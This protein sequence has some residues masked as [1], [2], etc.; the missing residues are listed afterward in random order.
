MEKIVEKTS[1]KTS[2]R[3][4]IKEDLRKRIAEM[5]IDEAL[6]SEIRLSEQYNTSRTTIRLAIGELLNE[7]LLY[8]IKG[9]GTY[10]QAIGGLVPSTKI[11][12]FS[13]GLKKIYS[14]VHL[15]DISIE[16]STLPSSKA[17]LLGVA[18][19]SKCWKFS[20]LWIADGKPFAYGIAYFRKD[21]MPVFEKEKLHLSLLETLREEYGQNIVGISNNVMAKMPDRNLQEKLG[22]ADTQPLLICESIEENDRGE[23]LYVDTRYHNAAGYVFSIRQYT[24]K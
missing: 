2:I 19:G 14:D 17:H 10:K 4:L 7:G 15:D 9:S 13:E 16:A 3:A 20:R 12:G 21:L 18:V 1:E 5:E 6:P 23:K 22:V 8:R 24:E 11:L